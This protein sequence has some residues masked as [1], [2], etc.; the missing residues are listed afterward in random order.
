MKFYTQKQQAAE[1]SALCAPGPL[2][3]CNQLPPASGSWFFMLKLGTGTRVPGY[4]TRRIVYEGFTLAET[5]CS[6][7]QLL[8]QLQQELSRHVTVTRLNTAERSK[9]RSDPR[10]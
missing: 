7:L 2:V 4:N 1:F 3:H 9:C 5:L 6:M 10:L 8:E